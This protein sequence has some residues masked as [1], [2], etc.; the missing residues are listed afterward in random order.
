MT[1]SLQDQENGRDQK[2][3]RFKPGFS[4]N[5]AGRPTG[6]RDK[7]DYDFV[8]ALQ[9]EFTKRGTA[10]VAE[11]DSKTLC[12]LIVKILPKEQKIEHSGS[13]SELLQRADDVLA[14]RGK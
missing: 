4:G 3:G 9:E 11:L 14:S 13:W 5:P 6:K 10:A 12:E 1:D 7:L 2:T 8:G